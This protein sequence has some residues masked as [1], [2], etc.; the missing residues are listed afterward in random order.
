MTPLPTLGLPVALV[1]GPNSRMSRTT[2]TGS[3]SGC[4]K[5]G[6]GCRTYPLP[7]GTKP[8]CTPRGRPAVRR[9]GPL[10][11]VLASGLFLASTLPPGVSAE[12]AARDRFEVLQAAVFGFC[13]PSATHQGLDNRTVLFEHHVGTGGPPHANAR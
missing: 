5:A 1:R 10:C 2:M 6:T 3:A 4:K 9:A 11:A 12:P 13:A 8:F 7:D